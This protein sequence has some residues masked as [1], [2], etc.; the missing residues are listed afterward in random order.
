MHIKNYA[1]I[2]WTASYLIY[3]ARGKQ[4]TILLSWW[5]YNK[6]SMKNIKSEQESLVATIL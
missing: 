5:I 1:T 4:A 3:I 2:T 6:Y